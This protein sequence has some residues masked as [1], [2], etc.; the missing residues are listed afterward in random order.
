MTAQVWAIVVEQLARS[1]GVVIVERR[2]H[3]GSEDS[4]AYD[5]LA[6]RRRGDLGG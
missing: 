1:F 5:G 4:L 6:A 2:G 3:T